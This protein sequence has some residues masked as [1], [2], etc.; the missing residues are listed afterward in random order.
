MKENH[1]NSKFYTLTEL[2]HSVSQGSV[3]TLFYSHSILFSIYLN[4]VFILSNA[5]V[6]NIY[7]RNVVTTSTFPASFYLEYFQEIILILLNPQSEY[8]KIDVT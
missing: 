4:D 8:L 7:V 3:L 1:Y 2:L 5:D 6:C